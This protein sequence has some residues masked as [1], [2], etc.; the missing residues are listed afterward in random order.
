MTEIG[1][2]IGY[3][4]AG[5]FRN[6]TNGST[7]LYTDTMSF[8]LMFIF[9]AVGFG[10]LLNVY[11]F[12]NWLGSATVIAVLGV[13]LQLA[14]LLQKFWFSVFVTSFGNANKTVST[15][16]VSNFW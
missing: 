3:G 11:R 7:I 16:T 4:L 2:M 9:V 12:G 5:S 1:I 8:I 10:M 13:S 15:V 6:D 14:P